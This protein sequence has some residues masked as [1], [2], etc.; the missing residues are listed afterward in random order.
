MTVDARHKAM[1]REMGVR[2]WWPTRAGSNPR[3]AADSAASSGQAAHDAQAAP[4]AAEVDHDRAP[5]TRLAPPA[6]AT[7]PAVGAMRPSVNA[8]VN[9]TSSATSSEPAQL[10]PAGGPGEALQWQVGALQTLHASPDGPRAPRWLLLSEQR[11]EGGSGPGGQASE[12][13]QRMLHAAGLHRGCQVWL[14]PMQRSAPGGG[15]DGVEGAVLG[16]EQALA[17][18]PDL[19]FIM[20]RLAAQ[21]LLET[22][23]P[24]GRLRGQL[25]ELWGLPAIVSY[26]CVT[27][28]R[29]P[30]DK[31]KAWDDLCLALQVARE[32]HAQ[33]LASESD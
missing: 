26:D 10:L 25:H 14:A 2:L 33:R 8:T 19:V 4:L 31:A 32:Q 27:L 24:L 17:V 20:G 3:A 11:Q 12:L 28:L 9:E 15:Q 22:A 1:L 7:H 6:A 18:E 13:L 30:A 23:E 29:N 16:L 5:L 21:A